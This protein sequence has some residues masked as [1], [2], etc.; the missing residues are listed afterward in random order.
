MKKEN[1]I[2][3]H[4][5]EGRNH[6]IGLLKS[7]TTL[8]QDIYKNTIS[9]FGQVKIA[10]QNCVEILRKEIPDKRIRLRYEDKGDIEAQLF[11]GSDV[12]IFSMHTNV[13]KLPDSDYA[14][15]TSYIKNNPANA[16]CG[17]INIYNFLADSYEYNRQEDI[18]YLIGRIF[19]NKD[20]HFMVEGKGQLG[21]I[22]K[23]LM[24]QKLDQI[25]IRDI[26]LRVGIHAI[27]FDL[28]T[29][30][31]RAVQKAT[32]GDL[33]AR[34]QSSKLKTGKRLGFKFESRQNIS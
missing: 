27:N 33:L 4:L 28:Y 24:H 9:W 1:K 5:A 26:I 11:I 8:K 23:D 34:T 16:Y 20:D 15:Q 30:P 17:I 21:F 12:L 32:V 25:I 2:E 19:I 18:G 7:K 14:S 6:L 29:P 3:D 22:Y 10:L 13:F 31:Y